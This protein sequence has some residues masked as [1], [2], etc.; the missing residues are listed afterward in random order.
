MPPDELGEDRPGVRL[1][2]H[3]DERPVPLAQEEAPTEGGHEDDGDEADAYGAVGDRAE[4]LPTTSAT[5][6]VTTSKSGT[7]LDTT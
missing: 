2:E 3:G 7:E 5:A 1:L 6:P 4:V